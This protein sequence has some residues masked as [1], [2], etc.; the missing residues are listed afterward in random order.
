MDKIQALVWSLYTSGIRAYH[1]VDDKGHS[2]TYFQKADGSRWPHEGVYVWDSLR[3]YQDAE[4]KKG[5]P[6]EIAAKYSNTWL[7]LSDGHFLSGSI[8]KASTPGIDVFDTCGVIMGRFTN[9]RWRAG[10]PKQNSCASPN[11]HPIGCDGSACMKGG[12]NGLL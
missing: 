3:S 9:F 4:R 11:C 6:I 8:M 5:V 10:Y 2:V 12:S 1:R 7:M